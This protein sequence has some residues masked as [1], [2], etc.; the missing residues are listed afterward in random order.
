MVGALTYVEWLDHCSLSGRTWYDLDEVLDVRPLHIKTVG[1]VVKET[2]EYVVL[3]NQA[4]EGEKFSG[5]ICI[6][7]SCVVD[8]K[9]LD[10]P[11]YEFDDE[12]TSVVPKS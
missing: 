2:D 12:L 11:G 9:D 5:D 6:I 10:G 1:W 4:T 7:K 8:R 3:A